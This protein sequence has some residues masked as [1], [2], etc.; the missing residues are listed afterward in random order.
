[1]EVPKR[2]LLFLLAL[3]VLPGFAAAQAYQSLDL[4]LQLSPNG[5]TANITTAVTLDR[6]ERVFDAHIE[7]ETLAKRPV[8]AAARWISNQCQRENPNHL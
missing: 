1:M 7:P 2:I 3:L 4:T 5:G 8:E 6:H